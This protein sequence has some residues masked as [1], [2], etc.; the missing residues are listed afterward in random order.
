MEALL[1]HLPRIDSEGQIGS[2]IKC[3]LFRFSFAGCQSG[4]EVV[5]L[6]QFSI[7]FTPTSASPS[8]SFFDGLELDTDYAE[9][10]L[11]FK[12]PNIFVMSLC[13]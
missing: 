3:Q 13:A 1:L 2:V 6:T 10:R 5:L 11:G 9:K 12:A 4:V 8:I 7:Y